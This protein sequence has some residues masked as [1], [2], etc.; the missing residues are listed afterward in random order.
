[1]KRTVDF[2]TAMSVG[3]CSCRYECGSSS[4]GF[5]DPTSGEWTPGSYDRGPRTF[6]CDRCKA[7]EALDA[8]G[9]EYV[10]DDRINWSRVYEGVKLGIDC[11]NPAVIP[12]FVTGSF[13][14][15]AATK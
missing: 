14:P 13:G 7:R 6:H 9:I 2:V 10:K 3:P 11:A 8:D 15:T 5:Y 1:M 12:G 4:S